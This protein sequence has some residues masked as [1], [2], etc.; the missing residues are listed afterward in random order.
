VENHFKNEKEMLVR[1][2]TLNRNILTE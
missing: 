1:L 2:T